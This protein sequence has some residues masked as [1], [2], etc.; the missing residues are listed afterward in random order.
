MFKISNLLRSR[1]LTYLW[2]FRFPA[3]TC[4]LL[5]VNYCWGQ[6]TTGVVIELLCGHWTDCLFWTIFAHKTHKT[7]NKVYRSLGLSRRGKR[8]PS[9]A[10]IFVI[11]FLRLLSEWEAPDT[12]KFNNNNEVYLHDHTS[13]YN[14]ATCYFKNQN[15]IIGKLRYFG[16]VICHEDQSKLKYI[17]MNP[18]EEKEQWQNNNNNNNNNSNNNNNKHLYSAYIAALSALHNTHSI[19]K[20]KKKRK[21]NYLDIFCII[22]FKI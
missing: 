18:L 9:Q 19:V 7:K 14:V 13:T 17:F 3:A 6:W 12:Q 2:L 10:S 1:L 16:T 11:L 22:A 21:S 8:V 4:S 15:Y 20:N 5:S